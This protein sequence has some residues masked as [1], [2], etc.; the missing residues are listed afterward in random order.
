MSLNREIRVFV[1]STFR[2]MKAERDYLAKFVFPELRN[3]CESRGVIWGDVDLRW[4]ITVEAV[5][6]GNVLPLCLNEIKRCRP[7]FI[8]LL[9]ERYGWIPTEPDQDL[10][11]AH[12][13]LT[14]YRGA[15]VTELEIV[16]GVLMDPAMRGSA[17][18][19]FRDSRYVDVLPSGTDRA[20]F[21]ETNSDSRERLSNL[22]NRIR[23]AR[24]QGVCTV[25]EPFRDAEALGVLVRQDLEALI[26]ALYPIDEVPDSVGLARAAH[27]NH[28]R[29][30]TIAYVARSEYLRR[31]DRYVADGG[32]PLVVT[33]EPGAGK[34]AFLGRWY[35]HTRT[36]FLQRFIFLHFVGIGPEGASTDRML[37]RLLLEI[38]ER[39]GW[40]QQ[41]PT[42]AISLRQALPDWFQRAGTLEPF[43]VIIDGLDHVED[44]RGDLDLNWLPRN[45]PEGCHLVLSSAGGRSLEAARQRQWSELHIEPLRA[46]D[47]LRLTTRFLSQYGKRLE[48]AVQ[49]EISLAPST[50]NPLFLRAMLEEIRLWA[51]H[52][53]IHER[54][55]YYLSAPTL[56]ALFDLILDR[57]ESDYE[58]NAAGL[59]AAVMKC[60]WA[61]RRG[62]AEAELLD[63]LG[64]IEHPLP[65]ARWSPIRFAAEKLL[66]D[67]GGEYRLLDG[68]FRETV[69]RR[70]LPSEADRTPIHTW[71][72]AYFARAKSYSRTIDELPW[73]LAQAKEWSV[74][75]DLLIEPRFLRDSWESQPT[76][77]M[78]Y[79][80]QVIQAGGTLPTELLG[81]LQND[82]HS[83]G[84]R[85]ML[86]L[87]ALLNS[88]GDKRSSIHVYSAAIA[89]IQSQ[90]P[91]DQLCVALSGIGNA[92]YSSG[93]LAG[94]LRAFVQQEQ[95]LREMGREGA[96]A[97]ALLNKAAVLSD[98]NERDRAVR[99]LMEAEQ[100]SRVHGELRTLQVALGTRAALLMEH[101]DPEGAKPVIAE[102]EGVCRTRGD[103][104]GLAVA[105]GYQ[106]LVTADRHRALDALAKQEQFARELGDKDILTSAMHNQGV[107]LGDI[108]DIDGA[109]ARFSDA[110][111]LAME[112]GAL[113]EYRRALRCQ[114]A[115]HAK[116]RAP[117]LVMQCLKDLE[118]AERKSGSPATLYR[119]LVDIVRCNRIMGRLHDASR[120]GAE[121]V[122]LAIDN[123]IQTSPADAVVLGSWVLQGRHGS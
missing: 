42:D 97:E 24:D 103:L 54:V 76:E 31:L 118:T 61:S 78:R 41:V 100:I 83:H 12:P 122:Q 99:T 36:Q 20:D 115:L 105:L 7:F 3:R 21:T 89:A 111:A 69:Q 106:A 5:A 90:G 73:Q 88:L 104:R 85:W 14:G 37:R 16:N 80:T 47:R 75:R 13:W 114:I 102:M 98:T 101:N 4:G 74:L 67:R 87:A 72:A 68:P 116:R 117:D 93:D 120:V 64:T 84:P 86:A 33:G 1:S 39:Y 19:Y 6:E 28:A 38:A 34:S 110:A 56:P 77:T 18:F 94:A 109:L 121:A 70:Y 49:R 8:G 57:F 65:R 27:E 55:S 79:W 123:A 51:D 35:Q 59:V 62:L 2:D 29:T 58:K 96:V 43:I 25:H 60:F 23:E 107:F 71:L 82:G 50:G 11:S 17:F 46:S 112:L 66:S 9:G 63:L 108:G 44:M 45:L 92:R 10:V 15:S 81:A 52:T 40:D 119:A 53:T 32:S 26:D 22:K 91:S 113:T 48:R 95:M 30:S